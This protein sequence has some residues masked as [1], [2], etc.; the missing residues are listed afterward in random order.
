MPMPSIDTY[1]YDQIQ[2]KLQ[3]ILTNRY[4]IEEI[5]RGIQPEV[6]NNFMRAYTG[7]HAREIPITYTMPQD[8]TSQQGA[9]YI[10]LRNGEETDTSIGNLEGTYSFRDGGFIKE[11]STVQ[12]DNESDRLYFQVADNIGDLIN[13]ENFEFSKSDEMT[14]EGNRIYF[15]NSPMNNYLLGETFNINYVATTGDEIGLRKGFTTTERYSVLV[16]STNMDTVRCLDLIV[17]AI[18]I[19]MR[20][21]QEE[22]DNFLLQNLQFGQIEEIPTGS[23]DGTSTPEI[24]YGRESIVTYKTSYN[25]EA[26]IVQAILNKIELN[27]EY[28]PDKEE[29]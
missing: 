29:A 27:I 13:V 23:P 4:I 20:D 24:L 21:N 22:H 5:L 8:K 28:L 2:S 3:I 25:L 16:V 1:L 15:A 19:L 12:L 17:K 9:I 26:P 18:L 6:A 14:I 10:G 11:A 7:E